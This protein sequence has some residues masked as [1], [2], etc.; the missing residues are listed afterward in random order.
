MCGV[1]L[2]GMNPI[3]RRGERSL[4]RALPSRTSYHGNEAEETEEHED[5][6]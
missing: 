1:K 4:R 5:A 2:C 6:E 3:G